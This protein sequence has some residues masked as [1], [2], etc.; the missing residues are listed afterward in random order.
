MTCNGYFR[1]PQGE[2]YS[3]IC[4]GL[5]PRF[6]LVDEAGTKRLRETPPPVHI[7]ETRPPPAV[8]IVRTDLCLSLPLTDGI[9]PADN[10]LPLKGGRRTLRDRRV[11]EPKQR[12]EGG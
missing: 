12:Y 10:L 6:V 1:Q 4:F 11:T 3:S 7:A 5:D 9:L 2:P 8:A